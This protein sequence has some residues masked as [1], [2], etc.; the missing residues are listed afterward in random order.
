MYFDTNFYL[1]SQLHEK[2]ME[3]ANQKNIVE[4]KTK[5]GLSRIMG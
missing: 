5:I 3:V 4:N 2:V 1:H